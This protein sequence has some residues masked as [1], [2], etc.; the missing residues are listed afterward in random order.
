VAS[1]AERV[2]D[3][4]ARRARYVDAETAILT[5]GQSRTAEGRQ[6]QFAQLEAIRQAIK[7]IDQELGALGGNAGGEVQFLR[8]VRGA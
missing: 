3:L 7:D 6:L 1:A 4:E 5:K 2:A 8:G